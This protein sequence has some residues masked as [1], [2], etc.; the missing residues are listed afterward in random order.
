MAYRTVHSLQPHIP[1]EQNASDSM[2]RDRVG[3]DVSWQKYRGPGDIG[4]N[5]C[6][7][8]LLRIIQGP[9]QEVDKI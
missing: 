1:V 6:Y 9:N 4:G 8:A 2:V 3:V 5:P 7:P